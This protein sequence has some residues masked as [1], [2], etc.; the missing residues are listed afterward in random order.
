MEKKKLL[1][2]VRQAH[3]KKK[4]ENTKV[5]EK[6]GLFIYQNAAPIGKNCFPMF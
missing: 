2:V 3:N 1:S 6:N 4:T 5:C